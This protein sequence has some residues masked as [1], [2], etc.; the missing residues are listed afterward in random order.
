MM[1]NQPLTI[2]LSLIVLL[3]LTAC[4]QPTPIPV[5]VTPTQDASVVAAQP[6]TPPSPIPATVTPVPTAVPTNTPTGPTATFMGPLVGGEYV[7]PPTATPRPT[8]TPLPSAT[9]PPEATSVLL[10]TDVPPT[11]APSVSSAALPN[12]DPNRM[13]IQLDP[14]LDQEDWNAAIE[15]IQRLGVKWLKVQVSWKMM[16]PNSASEVSE[17]FRRLEIYLET[18]YNSGFS[19]LVS[20][21]KAPPWARSNQTEDGP[22]DDPQ[23]LANFLN[24]LME[25]MGPSINVIEVWNEPNLQREWQGQSF[26]GGRYMDYFAPAYQAITAFSQAM[27]A[28]P[29]NNRSTPIMA[30]TAGLAPTGEVP[31]ARDDRV[32]LQEMYAAG[33]ANY[34]DIGV[35]FHPY[36]WGNSPNDSCCYMDETRGWDD[37]PHFFFKDNLDAYRQIMVDNGQSGVQLWATEFGW[38]TWDGFPGSPPEEWMTYNDRWQQAEYT[39]RAFQIGQSLDYMGPMFLWNLNFALLSGLIENRDERA[40]YSII[41]P[42]SNCVVDVNSTNRTERPLYWMLYDAIRPD[43][44]LDKYDC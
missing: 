16:Q 37:N 17:D 25:A 31:G 22:P 29:K 27:I 30:I 2:L 32:F 41:L 5:L 20:V 21:A 4:G 36:S 19:I 42:G 14:T 6:T 39:I 34:T 10:P 13:G 8:L 12:L 7:L 9:P 1:K 33:L 26:T 11:N 43:V 24:V 28:D 40:A 15:S 38:A 23:A 3:A 35:G 18:A 44:Q